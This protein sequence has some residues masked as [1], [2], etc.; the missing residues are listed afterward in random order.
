MARATSTTLPTS[1]L[2]LSSLTAISPL[3]GRYR[4]RVEALAPLV[5]EFGLIRA[6]VLV[7]IEWFLRLAATPGI[8]ELPALDDRRREACRAVYRDFAVADAERI[9]GIEARTNHDVKAVEYFVKDRLAAIEGLA[10]HVEYV[11]S[12][13][14][15]K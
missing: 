10:P 5:S 11:T 3:D 6:R 8:A 13:P 12:P 15:E 2:A 4:G 14:S 9:R 7:E 1:P